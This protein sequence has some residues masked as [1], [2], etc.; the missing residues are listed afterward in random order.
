MPCDLFAAI[1]VASNYLL[2]SGVFA[3]LAAAKLEFAGMSY[4]TLGLK[5]KVIASVAGPG[6]ASA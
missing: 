3:A 5:G 1:G 6:G 2:A 4:D